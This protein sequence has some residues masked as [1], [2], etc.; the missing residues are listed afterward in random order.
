MENKYT[1]QNKYDKANTVFVGLKLNKNTDADILEWL[2]KHPNR[3]GAIKQAI[4]DVI[5]GSN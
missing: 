4:R 1:A 5:K 3:Q 2:S